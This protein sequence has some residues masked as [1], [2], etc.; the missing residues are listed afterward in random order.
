MDRTADVVVIGGGV[1]GAS[2]AFHLAAMGAGEVML[3]E[4]RFLGAGASGKSGALVRMHYTNP[5][6]AALAQ[7]SLAYFHRWDELVGAGD[8]GFVQT[9]VIR[10]VAPEHEAA[11]RANVAML[12]GVGV[13]TELI[14]PDDVRELDPGCRVDDIGIAAYEPESGYADP[15]ATAFGLAERARQLGAD[16]R[17]GVEATGIRTDGGRVVG[18]ETADGVIATDTVVLANGA[19]APPLLASLGL[20][21]GLLPNRVQVV[22]F[23]RPEH[24]PDSHLTILDGHDGMWLRPEGDAGTLVGIGLDE[25]GVDPNAFDE[26]P[27]QSYLEQVRRCL[28]H[29]RPAMVDAPM[30]G[31]W[32]G[33][34][35][36]SP[37]A[38]AI[39]DQIPAY[40]GLYCM[41]GDSGTNF[42]TAPAIGK[43]LAEWIVDGA[44]RT[45]DLRPFRSS[46]FAEG[47]PLVGDHEY[48]DEPMNVFR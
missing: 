6:D 23:R 16:I 28:V 25:F 44:P 46:R 11:L 17:T 42:K 33:M 20:D 31:G 19:W 18:V 10:L 40:R 30:R 32:A 21:F 43:C 47:A 26:T 39:I 14:G 36:M 41:L 37:D 5:Y 9:G 27:D 29:R 3:L 48:G 2:T 34:I 35:T 15:S 45:V 22:V 38:H 7:E 1:N 13:N 4:R 12:Q 8:P 24:A